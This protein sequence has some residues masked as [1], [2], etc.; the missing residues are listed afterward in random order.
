MALFRP[1]PLTADLVT[2]YVLRRNGLAPYE[3]PLE[4]IDDILRPTYG[5]L[6]Y[7][8]QLMS[9]ASR[10]SGV[11]L[12]DADE[13]RRAMTGGSRGSG[14][15]SRG[16]GGG[17]QGSSQSTSQGSGG[18]GAQ[19]MRELARGF[20]EKAVR[21][22][23]PPDKAREVFGLLEGFGRY[24]F[25]AAHAAAF[26]HLAYAS[27]YMLAHH[28]AEAYAGILN[29]RPGMYSPRVIANEARRRG[30][31]ILP[32]DVHLS[33]RECSVENEGTAI[34][35]GLAYC[36]GL[37]KA[38]VADILRERL[39]KPFASPADLYRRTAV[40]KDSLVNLILAG[41]LDSLHGRGHGKGQGHGQGKGRRELLSTVGN[42][43]AK[44]N[45]GQKPGQ[46]PEQEPQRKLSG[47]ASTRTP[48][49]LVV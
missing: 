32:P 22:G 15:G 28:P 39:E 43:P 11:S 4:E 6:I 3:V 2:P 12:A 14:G 20:V 21:R 31:A 9:V 33:E 42:L 1:G 34:R 7:Q 40:T 38:A 37:S 47:R 45:R 36:R 26:A 44:K 30:V 41:F 35:I 49:E 16:S 29:A 8:E 17:S 27:A 13:L 48:G 10:L 25:S 18:A 5:C 19:R 23:V 46:K 24:G